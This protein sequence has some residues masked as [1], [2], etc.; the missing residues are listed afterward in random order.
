MQA[1][2]IRRQVSLG[3]PLKLSTPKKA[4]LLGNQRRVKNKKPLNIQGMNLEKG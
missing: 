3:P 1:V 4:P 2:N